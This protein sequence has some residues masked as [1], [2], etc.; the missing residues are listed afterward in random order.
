MYGM[1]RLKENT[2]QNYLGN[3]LD[4]SSDWSGTLFGL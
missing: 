4:Q 2:I 3:L 1:A